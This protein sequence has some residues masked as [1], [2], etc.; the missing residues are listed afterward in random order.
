MSERRYEEKAFYLTNSLTGKREEFRPAA[1][2]RVTY[3]SC[4]PTVYGPL[5]I[6]NA[7][8]LVVGELIFR[9]LKHIGYDVN[10]V[11]NYTDVDDKIINR[12]NEEKTTADEIADRYIAYCEEDL[13]LLALQKPVKTVRVRDTIPEIIQL[14]ERIIAR[15]HAYIVDG[16]VLY[17]IE[18]FSTYGKLSGKNVEDLQAGARVEVDK[19]KRNPMDFSLW[20]PQKAGE[21]GWD[22]PW[23][24]GRPG[25]HIECSAMV[26]RWLGETIDIHHGGQD[27]MFPHHENEIAQ[28]E[29]ATGKTFCR[30]WVHHAFLTSGNEKMSKSLGNILTIREFIERYSAEVLRFIFASFQYRSSIPYTQA[31][32]SQAL[33]EL[34]RIY[35][36]KQWAVNAAA[37][38]LPPGS[39]A[40]D[41]EWTPL[42][43][44][45]NA[46][47]QAIEE[48]MFNDLNTPGALGHLFAF[49][50]EL[51]RTEVQAA[52]K[53]GM[54]A[55][56]SPVRAQVAREFLEL[57]EKRVQPLLNVFAENPET[58]L[59]KIQAIRLTNLGS[60]QADGLPSEEE[61]QKFIQE[62]N[63]ARKNKDFKRADEIRELLDSRGIVLV[64]SV[65]GTMWR[66][67]T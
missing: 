25:W 56:A 6:G 48:E 43:A 27:L 26:W 20:K 38:A 5:H 61:I 30:H 37:Q 24:K 54:R 4:G 13:R 1:P 52:G 55:P 53:P 29:G 14:I 7:R 49:V 63:E 65:Q 18:S 57:L 3:Y 47:Y 32:M 44:K 34:E 16:E 17:S 22:S 60:S 28:S 15:G 36:A 35:L 31:M 2:P 67:K 42:V 58:V 33:G 64:D 19:K 46:V 50:R 62:R 9:W 41:K 39:H 21:P 10:F 66:A 23:G 40:T 8:A 11:R 45:A 59:A 51:N 12:A